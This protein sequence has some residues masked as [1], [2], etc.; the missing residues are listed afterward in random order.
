MAR[1]SAV[2]RAKQSR[3]RL[4]WVRSPP[5]QPFYRV[6]GKRLATRFGTEVSSQF[7]SGIPYQLSPLRVPQEV[8]G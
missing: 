2:N 1:H 5:P 7:D 4:R 3:K 6:L 8:A